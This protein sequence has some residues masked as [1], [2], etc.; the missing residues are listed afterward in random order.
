MRISWS[1]RITSALTCIAILTSYS[2]LFGAD[3]P[4][5]KEL[6]KEIAAQGWIVFSG[7]P[8]EIEAG[9]LI[10][11]HKDR[12]PFDLYLVRPDGSCLR[13]ITNTP[14]FHE[15][16]GLFSQDGKKLLYRKVPKVKP[17]NHNQWGILGSLVIADANGSCRVVHGKD[18]EFPWA[19]FGPQ[20]KQ[21]ACLYKRDG[22]IRFFDLASKKMVREIP[23]KGIFQQLFWSPDGKRLVGTANIAGRNWNIVSVYAKT[24]KATLL[25]RALNCTPDWFQNDP[26]RVIYSNRNPALFPGK[27]NNYGL[28]MLMQATADGKSRKLIYGNHKKH[29]YYGCTSPDDKYVLFGDDPEDS[30]VAGELRVLRLADTPIIPRSLKTLKL[31]YP[32]SK[33]GP[34]FSLKL[35][36]GVPLRGFEP[37]WT[38]TE[39]GEGQ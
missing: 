11:K 9:K 19:S 4:V 32:S 8:A 17:I 39:I 10:E 34:V 31:L 16:G 27:Y 18:G 36:G 37:H 33:E 5:V 20:D 23:N 29:C 6:G 24:G 21:I 3:D 13:N 26:E 14:D 38:Y 25:T 12:G 30:I 22:K 15:L 1:S 2:V 28:T 35:P 7:H